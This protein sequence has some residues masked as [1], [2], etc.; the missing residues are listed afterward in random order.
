MTGLAESINSGYAAR[1]SN[2]RYAPFNR[3]TEDSVDSAQVK[4]R[5]GALA[6]L[7]TLLLLSGVTVAV[8]MGSPSVAES[9][10]G[11]EEGLLSIAWAVQGAIALICFVLAVRWLRS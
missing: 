11:S 10:G 4:S 5:S 2:T 7:V 1:G 6:V 3:G 9:Y 8:A